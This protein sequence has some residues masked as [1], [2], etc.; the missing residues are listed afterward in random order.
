MRAGLILAI[1]TSTPPL[2]TTTTTADET[3]SK[4]SVEIPENTQP[5]TVEDCVKFHLVGE[6]DGACDGMIAMYDLGHDDFFEWNS[7]VD[8]NCMAL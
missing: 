3:N 2:P 6:N 5:G 4:T 1:T 7:E 8:G